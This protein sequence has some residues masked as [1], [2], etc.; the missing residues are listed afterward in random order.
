MK[1]LLFL[2][3]FGYA[4]WF[5]YHNQQALGITDTVQNVKADVKAGTDKAFS[6]ESPKDTAAEGERQAS[7]LMGFVTPASGI[8]GDNSTPSSHPFTDS[9]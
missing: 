4:A 9:R 5:A 6:T 2:I 8:V 1:K 3:I 7:R